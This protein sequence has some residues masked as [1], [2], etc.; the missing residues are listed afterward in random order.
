MGC[1]GLVWSFDWGVFGVFCGGLGSAVWGFTFFLFSFVIVFL[2]AKALLSWFLDDEGF[3][4]QR[5][6]GV[7]VLL[8]AQKRTVSRLV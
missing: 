6:K 4:E 1:S 3:P 5:G 2:H 8:R 7:S